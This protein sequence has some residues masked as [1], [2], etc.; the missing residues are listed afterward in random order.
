VVLPQ[1]VSPARRTTWQGKIEG[2][3]A[4]THEIV[5]KEIM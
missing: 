5:V 1:P 3:N 4:I 2:K